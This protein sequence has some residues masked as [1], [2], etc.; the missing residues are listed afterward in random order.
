[1]KINTLLEEF[2]PSMTQKGIEN[3]QRELRLI[4]AHVLSRPYEQ[5]YFEDDIQ[6]TEQEL[7]KIKE[8]IKLR[9]KHMPLAKILGHREFWGLPFCVTMDTL[10]PRPETETL[11]EALENLYSDKSLPLKILDLGTG[12]GCLLLSALTIFPLAEGLGVD[13]SHK[14]LHIA[15]KNARQLKLNQRCTFIYSD[16][17]SAVEG[18]WDIILSNPPY[19]SEGTPLSKETLYDP[20]LALFAPENG[21][22]AYRLILEGASDFLATNGVLVF[23]VGAGQHLDVMDL[24]AHNGFRLAMTRKDLSGYARCL[25]FK[26]G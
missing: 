20:K 12:S 16:W 21:L 5:I 24:A 14:A 6:I 4:V 18:T 3:P 11:L 13:I 23:E 15:Q 19:I 25:V 17:F 9:L 10:D 26:K 8:C 7:T 1:M 22:M 2:T